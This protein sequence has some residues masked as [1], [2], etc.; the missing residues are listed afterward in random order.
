VVGVVETG[1]YGRL[2]EDPKSYMYYSWP[3]AWSFDMTLH[4]RTEGDPA[5]LANGVRRIFR[6]MDADLPVYDVK[7]MENHLGY[8]LLP[9]QLGGVVLGI[10]GFLGLFLAAIGIY[11]VMAYSVAQRKAELGIRVALG[12]DKRRVVGLVLGEGM[13][14]AGIGAALGLAGAAGTARLV[15]GFLYGV[16][17]YD[18][19][20]FL[21][22]PAVLVAV[23]ALAVYLPARRAASLDPSEALRA[24]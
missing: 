13:V 23:A 7:S 4:V 10:F 8:A 18:P 24:E 21:V 6:D 15:Q 11:G 22:V 16:D 3:A 14:L 19:V 2:G 12:A 1:K 9:A 17:P 5:A 20:A